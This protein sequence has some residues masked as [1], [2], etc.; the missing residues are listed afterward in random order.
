MQYCHLK[1]EGSVLQALLYHWTDCS[2]ERYLSN[3]N[4]ILSFGTSLK[5]WRRRSDCCFRSSLI[6]AYAVCHSSCSFWTHNCL[7]K[8]MCSNSRTITVIISVIIFGVPIFEIFMVILLSSR[9][10]LS[11]I[12]THHFTWGWS[13]VTL[14]R[15]QCIDENTEMAADGWLVGCFGFNGPL[16]QYFSLYRA[17]SQRE[18]EKGEK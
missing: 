18:G 7:V 12:I 3:N 5:A 1:V 15:Q 14:S 2:Q 17:V 11:L 10:K 9:Q 8:P 16:K 13:A 6:R 4:I